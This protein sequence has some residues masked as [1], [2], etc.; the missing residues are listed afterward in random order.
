M[1]TREY[2]NQI[3]KINLMIEA[4]LDEINRLRDMICRISVPMNGEKVKSSSDPDKLTN[5]VAK[6]IKLE[7]E[8]DK[9]VEQLVLLRKKIISQIDAISDPLYYSVLT[10]RYVQQLSTKEIFSKMNIGKT[11]MFKIQK[12]ALLEFEK[13]YGEEYINIEDIYVN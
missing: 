1:T 6:I 5:T 10:Y 11:A 8:I 13:I 7:K 3:H 9:N 4:K 2:L 12:N